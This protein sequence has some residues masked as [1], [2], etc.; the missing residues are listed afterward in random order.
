MGTVPS[1]TYTE[2]LPLL[3]GEQ[4]TPGNGCFCTSNMGTF[5]VIVQEPRQRT[6][7]IW[8]G[9]LEEVCVSGCV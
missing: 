2:P 7:A 6:G 1:V 9:F 3:R 5:G 8:E 4:I